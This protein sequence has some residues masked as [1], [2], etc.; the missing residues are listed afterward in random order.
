MQVASRKQNTHALTQKMMY[1]LYTRYVDLE[2]RHDIG[3]SPEEDFKMIMLQSARDDL[4]KRYIVNSKLGYFPKSASEFYKFKKNLEDMSRSKDLDENLVLFFSVKEGHG[5]AEK[6]CIT[7]RQGVWKN[8]TTT[9]EALKDIYNIVDSTRQIDMH[10]VHYP[11][12]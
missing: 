10:I 5:A 9:A 7:L 12:T 8:Y 6:E 1:F 4:V 3:Q 11:H 2:S